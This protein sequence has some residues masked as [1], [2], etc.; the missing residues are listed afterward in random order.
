M[1]QVLTG[2]LD[3]IRDLDDEPIPERKIV[4]P[5]TQEVEVTPLTVKRALAIMIARTKSADPVRM[6]DLAHRLQHAKDGSM[7]VDDVDVDVL[8]ELV[9]SDK[10]YSNLVL[11]PVLRVLAAAKNP[12]P[13]EA[14]QPTPEQ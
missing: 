2:L 14:E 3:P 10:G 4:N 12:L 7:D 9:N 8:V 1:A 11:A 5:E 6:M 13:T